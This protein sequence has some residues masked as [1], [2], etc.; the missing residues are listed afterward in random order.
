MVNQLL[1]NLNVSIIQATR[2]TQKRV[3]NY[4][5]QQVPIIQAT[6]ATGSAA[7]IWLKVAIFPSDDRV[8]ARSRPFRAG[9]LFEPNAI[10]LS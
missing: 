1:S 2:A 4:G 5:C 6:R 10:A 7:V 8:S 9:F 3:L